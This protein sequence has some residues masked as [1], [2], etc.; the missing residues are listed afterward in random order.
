[1]VEQWILVGTLVV[2]NQKQSLEADLN[3]QPMDYYTL[4][5]IQGIWKQWKWKTETEN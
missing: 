5:S 3:W 4:Q 2:S 1:L